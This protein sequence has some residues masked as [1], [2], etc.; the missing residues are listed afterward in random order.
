MEANDASKK[1]LTVAMII[2]MV[3]WGISWPA[4][5]V[6]TQ[7]G[8][9]NDLGVYRYVFVVTSLLPLLFFLKVP[10]RIAKKGLPFLLISGL[11][12]AAYNFSFL[13]GLTS[14]SPGKGGILVTTLN[15]LMAYALGML[16]DW[17][18]PMKNERIGLFLG[19]TAGLILLEIWEGAHILLE[20]ANLYFL[21]AAVLWSVMSK[22]TS[23]SA[24][25]GS[26]FAFT[27]WMYLVTLITLLPLMDAEKVILLTETRDMRFWGN[28]IFSSVIVTT[29]A[30]T[31]YFFATSRIGAEKASSFIFT[32]P[33][34]AALS[35][36][37]I[38]GE[39]IEIHTIIG[40]LLG[41]GAVYMINRKPTLEEVE[42]DTL[43]A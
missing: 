12:M 2:S 14:G 23:R 21:L 42:A 38:L 15:P 40:G 6:L 37:L 7:F 4:N 1:Q 32:V 31:L 18:R 10:L 5:K 26:P 33:F 22:F 16:I 8:S 34:T 9:A 35:A 43:D 27:W 11:L 28:L 13:Q 19:V 30:T 39:V 24:S 29:F 3:F 36:A 25:Y 20:P 41:I 17:K